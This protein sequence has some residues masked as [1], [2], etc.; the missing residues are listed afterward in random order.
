MTI[1][2]VNYSFADYDGAK[3]KETELVP[4]IVFR[5]AKGL[6]LITEFDYWQLQ[7]PEGGAITVIDRS[8]KL[9]INYNF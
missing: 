7:Q 9:V 5:I 3:S 2:R 4:G 1:L 8:L 6:N